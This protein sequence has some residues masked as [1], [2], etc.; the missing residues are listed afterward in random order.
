MEHS[1]TSSDTSRAAP[2]PTQ[3]GAPT[4]SGRSPFRADVQGLRAIAVLIVIACHAGLPQLSGGFVGVDVFFV[5]SGY[6]IAQLLYR[7]VQ[8]TGRVSL[9]DFFARRARRILP[10]ATVVLLATLAASVVLLSVLDALEVATDALWATLF[11]ANV[12]FAAVGSDYFAQGQ[13]VSP[14]QHYW[15]LAVEE[16]FYLAWPILLCACLLLRRANRRLSPERRRRLPRLGVFGVLVT[17]TLASFGYGVWLTA[18]DPVAAYYSVPARAW[19]LALGALAGL[20]APHVAARLSGAD[21]AR[22]C[23]TGLTVIGVAAALFDDTKD[24]PGVAALAPVVGSMLVLLAGAGGHEREPLPIRALGLWPLRVVGNWSYSLYLWHWPVLV[25]AER[26]LGELTT[27]ET[28]IAL[29]ATFVL[30]GLTYVVVETPLRNPRRLRR[31]RALTLYPV[32]AGLVAASCLAVVG[33][34]ETRLG[35]GGDRPAI[36]MANVRVPDAVTPEFAPD[37]AVALVQASVVAA[38]QGMAVPSDLSPDLL[39]L[40]ADIPEVGACDYGLDVRTLCPRG[41]TYAQDTV[42]VLGNSHGRMWIPAFETIAEREAYR[43]FYFVK[44][45]CAAHDFDVGSLGD[46]DDVWEE[47]T[48]F[49]E[50]AISQIERLRPD[51]VVVSTSG[52]NPTLYDDEGNAVAGSEARDDF[53]RDGMAQTLNRLRPL[54]DRVVLVRDVP[55]VEVDPSTCLTTGSPDLGDCLSGT[56]DQSRRVADL[57]V[58]AARATGTPVVDPTRWV[59]WQEQCPVVIGNML[60]YRDQTHLSAVY[61]ESLADELGQALGIWT[62]PPAPSSSGQ[63]AVGVEG[64]GQSSYPR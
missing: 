49:R 60:P 42:V 36:T 40:S 35:E 39:D 24:F 31:R 58:Q 7:E 55:A 64:S 13:G 12:R 34:G 16:Q 32:S 33:Y 26:R 21:R 27:R 43:T 38:R 29:G 56:G 8:R 53:V 59:C 19:E 57:S 20:V 62:A 37:P 18:A 28:G 63:R 4:R 51:L 44:Q 48:D 25:L 23:L 10:A 15:S 6:L 54:A 3:A 46:S 47:C 45:Q 52:P 41:N 11:A 9:R 1:A 14:L 30:A 22:L 5:I 17:V 61:A 2:A 50:W